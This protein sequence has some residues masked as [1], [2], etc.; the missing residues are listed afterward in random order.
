MYPQKLFDKKTESSN[1]FVFS[2]IYYTVFKDKACEEV[3][4]DDNKNESEEDS[5]SAEQ[6]ENYL[7]EKGLYEKELVSNKNINSIDQ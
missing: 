4:N 7:K 6:E 2:L 5:E 3:D 1:V